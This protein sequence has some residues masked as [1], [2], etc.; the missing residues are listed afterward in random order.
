[1]V[2]LNP[3]DSAI[4]VVALYKILKIMVVGVYKIEIRDILFL[5]KG[6]SGITIGVFSTPIWD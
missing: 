6:C 2:W 3:A 4:M 5:W 1:V